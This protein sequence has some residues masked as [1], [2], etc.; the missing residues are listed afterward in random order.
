M[1]NSRPGEDQ[2]DRSPTRQTSGPVAVVGLAARF[3]RAGD[4]SALWRRL[5]YPDLAAEN[6][7]RSAQPFDPIELAVELIRAA[8]ADAGLPAVPPPD[9]RIG[10]AL[11]GGPGLAGAV[12]ERLGWSAERLHVWP[13]G[14]SVWA[15]LERARLE[16]SGGGVDLALIGG[17]ETAWPPE[18]EMSR[19]RA[20]QAGGG[21]PGRAAGGGVVALKGPEAAAGE[22]QPVYALIK[23]LGQGRA[24]EDAW[25]AI[26][27][28]ALVAALKEAFG[29]AG[30]E[31]GAVELIE[32]E[33]FGRPESDRAELAA[34][35]EVF[36]P[37]Q[38]ILP[39]C[40]LGSVASVLG[41]SPICGGVAALIK[42]C[43]ALHHRVL[44]AT[45]CQPI[46]PELSLEESPF[47]LNTRS[48]PWFRSHPNSPR[49]AGLTG[50]EPG[51]GA[52]HLILE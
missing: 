22:G 8:W 13:E 2:K 6:P 26:D 9:R 17:L 49:R 51:G 45:V 48:R 27:R 36:G 52:Y 24:T 40:G 39:G 11:A 46:D 19:G 50:I 16:L 3:D 15:A 31:P 35:A 29:Q 18:E 42:L 43:L 14:E 32:V 4:A 10:L 38:T 5:L 23:A 47:Y 30:L 1:M 34:L 21:G 12:A 25:P 33:G 37:R 20:F 28:A 7:P 44:P 41:H